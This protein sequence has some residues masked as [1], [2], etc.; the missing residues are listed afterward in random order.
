MSTLTRTSLS[1]TTRALRTGIDTDPAHGA[2]I[3]P[4]HLSSNSAFEGLGRPRRYDYTRSG[5]PTRDLLAEALTT[6]EGG[7]G[8][9]VTCTGMA[10]VTLVAT[11]FARP[12]QRVV[13]PHDAYGGTWRLFDELH[14]RGVLEV[15]AVDQSDAAAL[16]E[17]LAPGAALVW[18]ETPSNPLLRVTDVRAVADAAHRAGALVAADNTFC[19]PLW[20]QPL[21]LGAD[22]V[23]HSTTKYLNG[24][25]DVVGGAVVAGTDELAEQL[26]YWSNVLG[27]TGAPF[28]SYLTLRGLRTLP[29]RLR[30]H[31]EGTAAVLDALV[32]HPAVAAVHHPGLPDHPGHAVAARQQQGF[33]AMVSLELA[34]GREAV[35]RFLDGLQCFTLAESL[36]GTESL[37]A[38]PPTMTHAS[39]TPEAREVAG[40]GEGLLRL[41]VGLEDPADLAADVAAGLERAG[42][43]CR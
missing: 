21:E 9:A 19:T 23:V 33:G 18:V 31:A 40:I 35:A 28:D 3:P 26:A 12:G 32:G 17:A 5:N 25:S 20:Q 7:A 43:G 36:G 39:M 1:R 8:A 29:T 41:S 37:V 34:G 16:A 6:L 38:H 30:A 22:L 24:H 11:G 27:I 10:A 4:L 13:I 42:G 14:R 15:V 2:V